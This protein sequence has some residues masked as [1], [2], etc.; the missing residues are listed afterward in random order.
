ML[1]WFDQH[2]SGEQGSVRSQARR[3][4]ASRGSTGNTIH[5]FRQSLGAVARFAHRDD[6]PPQA[7]TDAINDASTHTRQ[8]RDLGGFEVRPQRAE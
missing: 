8:R 2:M 1:E 5:R 3:G 4:R 6:P 7:R